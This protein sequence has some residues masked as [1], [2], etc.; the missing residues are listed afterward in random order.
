[1]MAA[2]VVPKT[3]TRSSQ[4]DK[5]RI[6][7]WL[8]DRRTARHFSSAH[9][10]YHVSHPRI[11]F[12]IYRVV[13]IRL[14]SVARRKTQ[15]TKS[16]RWDKLTHVSYAIIYSNSVDCSAGLHLTIPAT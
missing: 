1:M 16:R 3:S 9:L 6:P 14:R 11:G 5:S 13:K 10:C 8:P 4:K 2:F 12:L 15:M 7:M